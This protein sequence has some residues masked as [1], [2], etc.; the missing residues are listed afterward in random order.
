MAA[1]RDYLR[2]W[3]QIYWLCVNVVAPCS[4]SERIL[5]RQL[6]VRRRQRGAACVL[7]VTLV[8]AL[9]RAHKKTCLSWAHARLH[10]SNAE[11]RRHRHV[12]DHSQSQYSR[13]RTRF[14]YYVVF[15]QQNCNPEI[16][17]FVSWTML[18]VSSPPNDVRCG[19]LFSFNTTCT[20]SAMFFFVFFRTLEQFNRI[21]K[22]I[23]DIILCHNKKNK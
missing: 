18:L 9:V 20:S 4:S 13:S 6:I 15:I 21:E 22:K 2:A 23:N 17:T 14:T 16:N 12:R 3:T 5:K 7:Y 11:T 1:A 8:S 19:Q 10:K